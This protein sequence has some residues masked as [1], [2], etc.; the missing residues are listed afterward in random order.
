MFFIYL[1]A[2]F[3]CIAAISSSISSILARD[4]RALR[5]AALTVD[6][7]FSWAAGDHFVSLSE[8]A[9]YDTYQISKA[10][11][12]VNKTIRKPTFKARFW[13]DEE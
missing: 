5:A 6:S 1:A 2:C 3:S 13:Y 12:L 11:F 4:W 9:S 8:S 10:F 7:P